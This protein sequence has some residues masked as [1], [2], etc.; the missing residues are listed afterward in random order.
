MTLRLCIEI[1]RIPI[2]FTEYRCS[3]NSDK[4][5]Y[6]QYTQCNKSKLDAVYS[7]NNYI[8]N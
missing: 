8:R 1:G 3:N 4:N 6:R 7:H 2:L 5:L